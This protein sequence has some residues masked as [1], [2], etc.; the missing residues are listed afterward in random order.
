MIS[1]YT[2]AADIDNP[3]AIQGPT[4]PGS[5]PIDAAQTRYI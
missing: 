1:L 4:L 5:S 2:V 3:G